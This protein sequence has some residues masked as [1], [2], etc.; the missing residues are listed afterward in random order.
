MKSLNVEIN[1]AKEKH[2][3]VNTVSRLLAWES[4]SAEPCTLQVTAA[5]LLQKAN[6]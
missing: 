4:K 5:H 3:S 1:K 6:V 2:H